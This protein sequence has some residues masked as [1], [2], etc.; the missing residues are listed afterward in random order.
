[1]PLI[2]PARLAANCRKTPESAAW[3]T[4]LP[5]ILSDLEQRWSLTLGT[6][7][8]AD[9]GS[10]AWVAPVVRADGTAAVLKL[11]MPHMESE[12][13]IDGLHF[14]N[15]DPTVRLFEADDHLGVMLLERCEPG[16]GLRLLPEPEQDLV[17]AGLL[18]RLWRPPAAPHPFRPLSAMT[19]QWSGETL[20]QTEQWP[21]RGLV[22]AGLDLFKHLSQSAP[23]DVLLATDLHA[24][25][26]LRARREPWLVIDPK[27][28][29]GDPAYDATQHL[30]NCAARLR[31]DP[32]ETIRR[33]AALL[34]VDPAR[35]CQWTF[36]RAAAE[37]RDE[38]KDDWLMELARRLG[39]S[40][41]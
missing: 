1:V 22:R 25:N 39:T 27:P 11:G 35:V 5:D 34:G 29:V 26:I 30:L 31:A 14:W 4:Q 36:A 33:F 38:W 24:G 20:R 3:L 23:S 28:F 9:Q 13:E 41:A 37:P 32:H 15:G 40:R 8:E 12:H 6:P 21:D 16:T 19:A 2:V 17:V 10:C 7:F 18:K